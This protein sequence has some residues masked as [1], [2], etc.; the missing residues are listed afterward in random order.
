M[1]VIVPVYNEG[2]VIRALVEQIRDV[3]DPRG[4]GYEIIIVDD[5]S[6]DASAREAEEGGATVIT[7]PYRKGNGAALKTGMRQARGDWFIL[8]DGDRQHDP[9]DIPTL[10]DFVPGYDLVVGARP[11]RSQLPWRRFANGIY[12]RFASYVSGFRI[13]DLTSGYRIVRADV[14]R[15]FLYLIPN[16][17]SGPATMT[18]ASIKSGFSV[19]FVPITPSPRA[20]G[21]SKINIVSDGTR[22]FVILFKIATLFSPLKIFLP[23]SLLLL[24]GGIGYTVYTLVAYSDFRNMS[25]VIFVFAVAVFVLGLISEQIS[26]LRFQRMD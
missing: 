5:G 25:V 20:G 23:L 4:D 6:T 7:H 22:F 12:N 3:M 10:L 19:H 1:S 15:S 18:I 11:S 2:H 24:L 26:Q 14:A 21:K 16:T 8:M 17:F 13:P 9:N